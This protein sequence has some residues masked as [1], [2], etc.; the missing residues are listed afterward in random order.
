MN[1]K[2]AYDTWSKQY[3]TT[4]NKTRDLEA[5][6]L[7]QTLKN[8]NFD[9][10]LEIGCGTG[11]N[12][13]WFVKK[14]NA[15]T[16]IDLSEKMLAR[17]KEKIKSGN[18]RFLQA[19]ISKNWNFINDKFDIVS[20]SLILEHIENLKHIFKEAAKVINPGGYIY[21]GELHPFKRE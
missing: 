18:V 4:D 10:C 9:N 5:I 15:I 16:A 17:A 12:T 13:E 21:I 7:R 20:F 1:T 19:D 3:D 2:K 14:A 8:I 6:A 11:K